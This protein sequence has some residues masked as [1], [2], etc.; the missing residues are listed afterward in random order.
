MPFI[1]YPYKAFISNLSHADK[2]IFLQLLSH[3]FH[4]CKNNYESEFYLTDRDLAG[5]TGCSRRTIYYSK[6]KLKNEGLITF[7][8]G[9]KN[10]TYY[11]ITQP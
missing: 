11:Q 8:R 1:K 5:L 9:D 6:I 2:T 3:H 7:H 10:R 4:Y